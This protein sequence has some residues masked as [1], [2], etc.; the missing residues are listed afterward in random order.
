MRKSLKHSPIPKSA[1][2]KATILFA[3]FLGT[4]VEQ[5]PICAS[6]T[7][8]TFKF[9]ERYYFHRRVSVI[10]FTGGLCMM[11]LPVGLHGPMLVRGGGGSP[12]TDT[13]L[14]RDPP[15]SWW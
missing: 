4:L 1:T 10:L 11:S 6:I 3:H 13:P 7:Q 12:W 9:G 14:D 15:D 8:P 5:L 2:E